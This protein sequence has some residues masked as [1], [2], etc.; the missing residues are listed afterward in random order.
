MP[1]YVGFVVYK[2]VLRQVFLPVLQFSP[3]TTIPPMLH[4]HLFTFHQHHI[5]LAIYSVVK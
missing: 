4:T 2:V 1:V 3:V 5:N